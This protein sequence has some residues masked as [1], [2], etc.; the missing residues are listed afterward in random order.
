MTPCT[1]ACQ[2]I[3]PWHSPGKNTGMGCH[4][5]LKGVFPIQGSNLSPLRWQE[6]SWPLSP[7]SAPYPGEGGPFSSP[8]SGF[9]G[10]GRGWASFLF[11]VWLEKSGLLF[12]P[13]TISVLPDCLLW[14]RGGEQAFVFVYFL[15][16]LV[17]ISVLL[18]P[19]APSWDRW[20]KKKTQGTC[21]YIISQILSESF[22]V[23]LFV[24]C[25][26]FI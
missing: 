10:V 15:S 22:Y 23:C 25:L 3:C 24:L 4:F 20:G 5:L 8:H 26:F 2:A 6:D 21:Y 18:T 13:L 11:G 14:A 12:F 7:Q 1:L 9:A 17:G 19:S 16:A